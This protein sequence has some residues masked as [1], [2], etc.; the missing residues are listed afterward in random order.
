MPRLQVRLRWATPRL[1]DP[2][3]V[4]R[5]SEPGSS[6]GLCWARGRFYDGEGAAERGRQVMLRGRRQQCEVLDGL[7][8]DAQAGRSRVLVVRGEP[9]IGK[10]APEREYIQ[11]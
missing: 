10:T 4:P 1:W 6:E 11:A 7:L 5:L 9:G 2:Q 3:P 8:A